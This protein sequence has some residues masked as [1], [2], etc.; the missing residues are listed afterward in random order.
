MRA[1]SLE[2]PDSQRQPEPQDQPA[3]AGG[4]AAGSAAALPS[5]ASEP[6][7]LSRLVASWRAVPTLVRVMFVLD[8]LMGAL[9]FASRRAKDVIP[10]PLLNFFDL[11][12]E[13]NLPSWYSAAQLGLIGGLIVAFAATQLL[14]GARAAWALV[15]AGGAFLFLSVDEATSL[16]EHFGYWLDKFQHRRGTVLRETGFWMLICAPLFL[17]VMA[18]LGLAARR[19]LRGRRTVVI[20]FLVGIGIFLAAAAGVEILSNFVDPHAAGARA[21]VLL[22]ELGEMLGATMMLW[23]VM[24]LAAAHGVRMFVVNDDALSPARELE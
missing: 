16:H 22:E 8:L 7:S 3:A 2:Y 6:G 14:R 1:V 4:E 9:Y 20:K 17:A 12:G 15:L 23:G 18:L 21:L 5:A 11:N 19:Y 10:K 13:T 24:E